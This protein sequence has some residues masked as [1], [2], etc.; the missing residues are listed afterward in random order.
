MNKTKAL[1]SRSATAKI[2]LNKN[3]ILKKEMIKYTKP[4][5]GISEKEINK[6]IGKKIFKNV[7]ENYQFKKKDFVK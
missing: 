4:G 1:F 3:T 5:F 7:K 6:Y 2:N